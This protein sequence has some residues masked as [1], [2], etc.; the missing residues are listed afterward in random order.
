MKRVKIAD[1][2]LTVA[3]VCCCLVRTKSSGGSRISQ[4]GGGAN[5]QGG[6][7]N[8]LFNQIFPENCMK[9]KEFGPRGEDTRP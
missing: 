1:R 3:T 7:A 2:I 8:L 9:M 4:T 5:F 6:G